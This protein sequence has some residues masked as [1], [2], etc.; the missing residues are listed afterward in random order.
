MR[1]LLDTHVLIW[2]LENAEA[3][4]TA[5]QG[6]LA[7]NA[8]EIFVSAATIWEI[9]IKA[10]RK[11]RDFSKDALKVVQALPT[12][13]YT[14]LPVYAK[15]SAL[16]QSLPLIH[17]DP[18]DRILV[19]QAAAEQLILVTDDRLIRQYPVQTWYG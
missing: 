12:L 14:E 13:G 2:S 9:A 4:P 19:A 6:V 11:R 17:Q 16:V 15:H 3:L 18:F 7:D 10:S 1:L 5:V 8:H